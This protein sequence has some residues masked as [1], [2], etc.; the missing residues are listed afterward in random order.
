MDVDKLTKSLDYKNEKDFWD[1]LHSTFSTR[2]PVNEDGKV[3]K[4]YE[5]Y[6]GLDQ[7]VAA[8]RLTI[9][10]NVSENSIIAPETFNEKQLDAMTSNVTTMIPSIYFAPLGKT[11][12]FYDRQPAIFFHHNFVGNNV[13]HDELSRSQHHLSLIHI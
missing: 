5:W 10:C 12:E 9:N 2:N 7:E 1:Y 8:I 6:E 13:G 11:V 4:T 3:T